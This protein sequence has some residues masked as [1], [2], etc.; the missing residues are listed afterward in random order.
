MVFKGIA[1]EPRETIITIENE[2]ETLPSTN[3]TWPNRNDTIL[4]EIIRVE[5]RR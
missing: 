2:G 1:V 3:G 5:A 4:E